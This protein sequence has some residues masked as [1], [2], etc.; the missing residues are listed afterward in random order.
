MENMQNHPTRLHTVMYVL[1]FTAG[2]VNRV[3]HSWTSVRFAEL[4][5]SR[6]Y[7]NSK[8]L[9]PPHHHHRKY[10]WTPLCLPNNGDLD[11][12]HHCKYFFTMVGWWTLEICAEYTFFR[13]HF[14]NVILKH[15]SCIKMCRV[16]INYCTMLALL[17]SWINL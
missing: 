11:I 15:K 12:G 14:W 8:S 5:L 17:K 16:Q 7:K 2:F 13:I 6:G 3:R 4:T 9:Q 1:Y 10:N